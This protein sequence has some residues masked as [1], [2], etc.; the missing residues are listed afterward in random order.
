MRWKKNGKWILT[1]NLRRR[2]IKQRS[3]R[4]RYRKREKG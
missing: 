3:L 2:L 1:G 4:K